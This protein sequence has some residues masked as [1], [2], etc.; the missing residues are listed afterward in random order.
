MNIPEN[1]DDDE[2]TYPGKNAKMIRTQ[3]LFLNGFY[4]REGTVSILFQQ[5]R[6]TKERATRSLA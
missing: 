3:A 6:A 4:Y 5:T 2:Y 1:M